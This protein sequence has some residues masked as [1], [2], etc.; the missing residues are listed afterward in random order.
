MLE[1]SVYTLFWVVALSAAMT[2]LTY[3]ACSLLVKALVIV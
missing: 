2:F 1:K 3:G